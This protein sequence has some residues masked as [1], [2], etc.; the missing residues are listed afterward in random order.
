MQQAYLYKWTH[1]P[2]S[3]WYVGS[4]TARGCHI[5]DG[6]LCSSKEVKPM[7]LSNP[8]EWKREILCVADSKYII[9]LETAYLTK[10]DAKNDSMSFNRH[11]GDGKFT[12][13]GIKA[14]DITRNK[15]S[16]NRKGIAKPLSHRNAIKLSLLNSTKVQTRNGET[17]PRFTGY[18]VSPS[19]E[20]FATAAQA[21]AKVGYSLRTVRKWAK[22]NMH[23][24]TFEQVRGI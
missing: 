14:S 22:A 17:A 13:T 10:L 4:R 12:S 2:S 16:I 6:Y 24:W 19:K 1:I 5:N 20:K 18:Y 11:N 23:G 7:I 8:I 15:M 3:R 9:D 21:V